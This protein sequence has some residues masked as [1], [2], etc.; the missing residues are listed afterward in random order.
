MLWLRDSPDHKQ[1]GGESRSGKVSGRSSVRVRHSA[2]FFQAAHLL[3][4]LGVASLRANPGCSHQSVN[5]IDTALF[6]Q[7]SQVI[8]DLTVTI[9]AAAFSMIP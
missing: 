4:A 7:L 3:H 1:H 5:A 6:T 8:A 2:P 9:H